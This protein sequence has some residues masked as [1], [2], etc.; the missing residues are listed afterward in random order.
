[1]QCLRIIVSFEM[2]PNVLLF[3]MLVAFVLELAVAIQRGVGGAVAGG[4]V[5]AVA[6][7]KLQNYM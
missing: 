4:A 6:G 3:F 1:M 7:T 2:R 5:G